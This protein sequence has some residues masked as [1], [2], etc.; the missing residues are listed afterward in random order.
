MILDAAS[1]AVRDVLSPAFRSALLKTMGL[2]LLFLVGLGFALVEAAQWWLGGTLTGWL[3]LLPDWARVEVWLGGAGLFGT[4]LLGLAV[5]FLMAFLVAPVSAVVAGLF[6][7]DAA[8]AIE[9]RDYPADEP[10]RALPLG[11]AVPMALRFMLVV[12]LVNLVA[13]VLLLVPGVNLVAFLVANGYLLGREFFDFAAMRQRPIA[14]ARALRR[15]HSGT[16][17]LGGLAIAALLAV[18]VVNLLVPLFG[19]ALMVHLHKGVVAR[20]R[21]LTNEPVRLGRSP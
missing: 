13:L 16:V 4:V 1:R 18:P 11:I 3:D 12:V 8:E 14:E 6:L 2:T 5:T 19:A 7:D 20:D 10:G 21:F 15:R 17:F 9:R